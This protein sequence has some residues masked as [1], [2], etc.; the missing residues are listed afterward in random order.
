MVYI[1]LT[2]GGLEN[3][4]QSLSPQTCVLWINA[5]VADLHRATA[6]FTSLSFGHRSFVIIGSL[7]PLHVASHPVLVHRPAASLSASFPQLVALLQLRFAST[8]M[9]SS[10]RDLHPQDSA[11]ARRTKKSGRPFERPLGDTQTE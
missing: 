10:R 8:R 9:T 11:P 4:L 5:D 1:V 7:A 6:V 2:A 3:V